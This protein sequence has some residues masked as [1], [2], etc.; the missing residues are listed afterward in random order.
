MTREDK[1]QHC[2]H[3][4]NDGHLHEQLVMFI[5][6]NGSRSG[7]AYVQTMAEEKHG[8]SSFLHYRS[9]A[10]GGSRPLVY[11]ALRVLVLAMHL[12]SCMTNRP[13]HSA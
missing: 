2:P 13:Q 7:D 6:D 10:A 8:C 11:N 9:A 4:H 5:A 12:D 1:W 3:D